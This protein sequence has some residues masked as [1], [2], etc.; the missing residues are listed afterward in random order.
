MGEQL[1]SAQAT[2]RAVVAAICFGVVCVV[3]FAV[4][5]PAGV[6]LP[7]PGTLRSSLA[8]AGD[9]VWVAFTASSLV[10]AIVTLLVAIG[11]WLVARRLN[12]EV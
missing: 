10:A 3:W 12:R 7:E 11:Y 9:P 5:Q 4:P 8:V 1:T 6:T 2:R